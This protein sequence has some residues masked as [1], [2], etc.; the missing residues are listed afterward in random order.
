MS[1]PQSPV[2]RL[3][4]YLAAITAAVFITLPRLGGDGDLLINLVFGAVAYFAA[5]YIVKLIIHVIVTR[6]DDDPS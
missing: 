5:Y 3:I 2:L 6:I 4:P 1:E